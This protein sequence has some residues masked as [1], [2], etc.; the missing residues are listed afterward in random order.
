MWTQLVSRQ[1]FR[2]KAQIEL[3]QAGWTSI[4][5][6]YLLDIKWT[7]RGRSCLARVRGWV[8]DAYLGIPPGLSK[9]R[10]YM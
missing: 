4:R 2:Q 10:R 3:P 5:R 9:L 6:F 1:G 8:P 7:S